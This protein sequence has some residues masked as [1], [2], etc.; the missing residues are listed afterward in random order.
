MEG[1]REVNGKG[2]TAKRAGIKNK[3][4]AI[5]KRNDK[6]RRDKEEDKVGR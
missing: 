3:K 2:K 6:K 4:K 5:K 1:R